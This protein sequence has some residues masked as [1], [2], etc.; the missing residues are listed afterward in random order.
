[1]GSVPN[2]GIESQTYYP[3]VMYKTYTEIEGRRK[4]EKG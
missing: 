2:T 3:P 4:K 1:M